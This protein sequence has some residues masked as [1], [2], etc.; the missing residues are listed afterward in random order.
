M[1]N[2]SHT[3]WL[4]IFL[5]QLFTGSACNVTTIRTAQVSG[6]QGEVLE[7]PV[8]VND[9]PFC[10]KLGSLGGEM[11]FAQPGIAEVTA[12]FPADANQ[13]LFNY[14]LENNGFSLQSVSPF[15]YAWNEGDT[16]FT[17][18]VELTGDEGT[19]TPAYVRDGVVP[20]EL[21]CI[22]NENN[23]Y[24]RNVNASSGSISVQGPVNVGGNIS[25][26][27]DD[28]PMPGVNVLLIHQDDPVTTG[29]ATNEAG[30]YLF[31]QVE[32]G[33]GYQIVPSKNT[34]PANGLS[35]FGGLL[36]LRHIT[37]TDTLSPYEIIAADCNCSEELT[38]DDVGALNDVILGIAESF[39][40]CDSWKFIQRD[41]NFPDTL[42]PFPF[43]SDYD[44]NNLAS[45]T[46]DLDF[47]GIKTGDVLGNADPLNLIENPI[48][49]W[50]EDQNM[51]EGET[52]LIHFRTFDFNDIAAWQT[53]L[54]L[55]V[56]ALEVVDYQSGAALVNVGLTEKSAGKVRL[57]WIAADGKNKNLADDLPLFSL[58][59]KAKKDLTRLEGLISLSPAQLAP[60]AYRADGEV[61]PL[62]LTFEKPAAEFVPVSLPGDNPTDLGRV[63]YIYPNPAEGVTQLAFPWPEAVAG[64]AE[65][66]NTA[67]Q[68]V[69]TRDFYF[70]EGRNNLTLE[71][72]NLQPGAYAVRVRA[73]GR[74]LNGQLVIVRQP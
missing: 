51:K 24:E 35:T 52:A 13:L 49:L 10:E 55:D 43:P 18:V 31:S 14:N 11:Y 20:F 56:N 16:L 37:G 66:F 62:H 22:S 50:I 63:L 46:D 27:A 8:T 72:G 2:L 65:V 38:I 58:R 71:V 15:G 42:H 36:I 48:H 53:A 21:G 1:K 30:N 40:N 47:F 57:N 60:E 7:V 70:A 4:L 26:V 54:E 73:G 59:L 12:A 23:A 41:Y 28:A 3:I 29:T 33:Q 39:P 25:T 74:I 32:S 44:L 5:Q 45:E 67:G 34:N 61:L 69:L 19:S 9:M 68:T 17:L 64:T 6:A